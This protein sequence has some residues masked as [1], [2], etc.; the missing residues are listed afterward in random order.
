MDIRTY[1]DGSDVD[2]YTKENNEQKKTRNQMTDICEIKLKLDSVNHVKK[3]NRH[4]ERDG[5]NF[6]FLFL[7][8]LFSNKNQIKQEKKKKYPDDNM[9][10]LY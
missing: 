5:R 9:L 1:R 3:Q 8:F 2:D 4:V 10:I 6:R 7:F